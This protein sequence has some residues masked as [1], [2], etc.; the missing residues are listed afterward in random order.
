M[1]HE[2][3]MLLQHSRYIEIDGGRDDMVKLIS[4]GTGP[5]VIVGGGFLR[6]GLWSPGFSR[7][8]WGPGSFQGPIMFALSIGVGAIVFLLGQMA[9]RNP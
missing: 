4:I 7:G 2:N 3:T 8:R 6:L 5:F 9:E 1:V